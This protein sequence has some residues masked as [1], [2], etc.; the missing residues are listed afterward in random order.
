MVNKLELELAE[1]LQEVLNRVPIT[2]FNAIYDLEGLVGTYG[3]SPVQTRDD[4]TP[5]HQPQASVLKHVA[6]MPI[7]SG[8]IIQ[9]VAAGKHADAGVTINLH[10]KRHKLGRTYGSAGRATGAAARTAI[11]TAIAPFAGKDERQREET[12]KVLRTELE[13]DVIAMKAVAARGN[14][15]P[16]WADINALPLSQPEK[17]ALIIKVRRQINAGEDRIRG[18]RLGR[19][20]EL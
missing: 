18:Q 20:K 2:Q 7:F 1:I 5:D 16:A 3:T 12:I 13:A 9:S 11:Q 15:D 6:T 4:M 8:R 14:T 10:E 19:Y 17:D